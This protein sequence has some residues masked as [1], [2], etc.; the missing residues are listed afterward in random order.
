MKEK[1]DK[2]I[3][4][5]CDSIQIRLKNYNGGEE[6][7]AVAMMADS[8]GKLIIARESTIKIKVKD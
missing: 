2:T 7:K 4:M 6:F 3:E 8:L 1:I 5:M